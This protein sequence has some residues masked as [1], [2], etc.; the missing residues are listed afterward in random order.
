M[1]LFPVQFSTRA[2]KF[3]K[4]LDDIKKKRMG[5]KI[6]RLEEDPFPKEVERVE[7]RKDE[8]VFRVRVG[9]Y[10]ILYIVRYNPNKLI[11]SKVDKRPRV[12]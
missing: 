3:I 5:I 7:G 2:S 1:T 4:K 6:D 12:Y 9:D 8:K 11:I 10:R